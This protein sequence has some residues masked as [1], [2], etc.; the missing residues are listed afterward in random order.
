MSD[1]DL[2]LKEIRQKVLRKK[3][4]DSTL[5]NLYSLQDNI[6]DSLIDLDA[7][8]MREQSDVD[9]LE[10]SISPVSLFLSAI[11][12][13]EEKL[14]KER[15]EAYAASAKYTSAL[16]QASSI[17]AEI[18]DREKELLGLSGCEE[19]YAE[20][21]TRKLSNLVANGH[22]SVDVLLAREDAITRTEHQVKEIEEAILAGSRAIETVKKLYNSLSSAEDWGTLDMVG[23]GLMT[24][25]AKYDDLDEAQIHADK[26]QSQLHCFQT[27]LADITI[28]TSYDI[29]IDDFTRFADCFFDNFFMDWTVQDKIN[30]SLEQ[31]RQTRAEIESAIE[32]LNVLLTETKENLK[33]AKHQLEDLILSIS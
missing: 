30:H 18:Q 28:H 19:K 27:E 25:V 3:Y 11:G 7:K 9:R 21:L 14:D 32:N 16:K 10:S 4:L 17:A 5:T 20:Q 23:G 1:F 26:L 8:R 31:V 12:K 29:N 13:S 33:I 6:Q 24:G 2:E 22:K 15:A